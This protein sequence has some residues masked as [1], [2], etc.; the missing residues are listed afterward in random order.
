MELSGDDPLLVLP[1]TPIDTVARAIGYA[2][3]LNGGETCIAPR[4]ILA[5]GNTGPALIAQLQTL[6]PTLPLRHLPPPE[7][8]RLRAAI[9]QAQATGLQVIGDLASL[10]DSTTK[11]L[12]LLAQNPP[13]CLPP[14]FAPA[15]TLLMVQDAAT[16]ITIANTNPHA[17]GAAIFG[18]LHPAQAVA[19]QLRAGCIVIN[20]VIVPTA[21]PRLPFGGTGASG[22]GV[23]RGAEGLLDMTRPQALIARRHTVAAQYRPLPAS[24]ARWIGRGLRL[25]YG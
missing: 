15:A 24:A 22:F 17:L 2:L 20:D 7:A 11:P 10:R 6:L 14:L 18:P 21:D 4:R 5:I 12:I 1:G 13:Q 16:A 25:L 8:A 23:T 3:Q 19:R 9:T